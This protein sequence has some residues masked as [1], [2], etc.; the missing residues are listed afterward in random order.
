MINSTYLIFSIIKKLENITFTMIKLVNHRD[1]CIDKLK[2]LNED[3]VAWKKCKDRLQNINIKINDN[4]DD[5]SVKKKVFSVVSKSSFNG[6]DSFTL[7]H[8]KRIYN[9]IENGYYTHADLIISFLY[10]SL[11]DNKKVNINILTSNEIKKITSKLTKNQ[12]IIDKD[13]I[14]E[15]SKTMNIKNNF[16]YFKINDNG[17]NIIFNLIKEDCVSII[18]YLFYYKKLLTQ[19]KEYIIF[20]SKEYL[21]FE[22]LCNIIFRF[23]N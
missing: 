11:F 23:L 8:C 21:N 13:I 14:N 2:K 16:E 10:K 12:F 9:D 6:A 18:F 5:A 17:E 4:L 1:K 3:T 19:D 22:R 15:L 20:K 7:Y